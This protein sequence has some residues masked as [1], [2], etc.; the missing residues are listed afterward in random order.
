MNISWKQ[1][2]QY[3]YTSI[4]LF[5]YEYSNL[6]LYS[7]RGIPYHTEAIYGWKKCVWKSNIKMLNCVPVADKGLM[8]HRNVAKFNFQCVAIK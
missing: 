5:I 1:K 3:I 8:S 7:H 2:I 4:H 6:Y